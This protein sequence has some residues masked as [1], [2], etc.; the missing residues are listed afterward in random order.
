MSWLP[1][2]TKDISA[3]RVMF[4]FFFFDSVMWCQVTRKVSVAFLCQNKIERN[5]E[6]I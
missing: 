6:T 2:I 4:S 5:C 3:D 1:V